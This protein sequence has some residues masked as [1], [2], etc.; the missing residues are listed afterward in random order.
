[1]TQECLVRHPVVAVVMVRRHGPLVSPEDVEAGPRDPRPERLG[2]IGQQRV[3][4]PGCRAS[5]QGH[6]GHATGFDGRPIR[7]ANSSAAARW[8]AGASGSTRTS[9]VALGRSSGRR[10]T[11]GARFERGPTRRAHEPRPVVQD[12]ADRDRLEERTQSSLG[13]ERVEEGPALERRQQPGAI[14]PP[15]YTPAVASTRSPRLPASAP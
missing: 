8:T 4:P 14:P 11:R 15:R 6:E 5:R 12:D 1:M 9:G 2:G 3:E 7:A 13:G 10:V